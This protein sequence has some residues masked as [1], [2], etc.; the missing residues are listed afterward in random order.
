[1]SLCSGAVRRSVQG[2]GSLR[3]DRLLEMRVFQSV[4]ELGS[5]TAAAA[6]LNTTQPFVSR[7][8]V[9]L[10]ERLGKSL[11]RRSTRKLH[12]TDDGQVFLQ[13]SRR[14]LD[15]LD[16]LEAELAS[17]DGVLRGDIRVTAPT[18][19]GVDQ[20][21]P[22]I[23]DFLE[24]NP[25]VRVKLTLNDSLVDVLGE[26]FDVAIRMGSLRDS[27]LLSR[28]LCKLQRL[29]VAAPR[30]LQVH[31]HPTTPH[32]LERHNCFRWGPLHDHMN[33]WPFVVEGETITVEA[34]GNFEAADGVAAVGLCVK[35]VCVTR[36]AEHVAVPLIQQGQ[37][38]EVL[39]QFRAQDNA[40][41]YAVYANDRYRHPRIRAF[42]D[43]LTDGLRDPPWQIH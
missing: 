37:L 32:D 43:H 17:T 12:I 3:D 9:A 13:A 27:Q 24:K 42:L 34:R 19:F 35:G 1:V 22:L 2:V 21:V 18:N 5:F 41:I 28:R 20:I 15:A 6:A 7:T 16:G 11:L 10:E 4:C 36:M 23:S 31:G 8:V 25:Q 29:V 26:G 40:A 38:V 33:K 30:Y 39:P 14:V